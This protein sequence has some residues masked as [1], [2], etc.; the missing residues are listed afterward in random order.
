MS[1]QIG[2][3]LSLPLT[4]WP[5]LLKVIKFIFHCVATWNIQTYGNDTNVCTT[6]VESA[7]LD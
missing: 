7:M 3:I 2:G 4:V 5:G 6:S 1:L